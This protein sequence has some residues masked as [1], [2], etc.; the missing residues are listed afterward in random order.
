MHQVSG[1]VLLDQSDGYNERSQTISNL[2]STGHPFEINQ[3]ECGVFCR[4]HHRNVCLTQK[5]TL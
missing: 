4:I 2:C 3:I 1:L 5:S